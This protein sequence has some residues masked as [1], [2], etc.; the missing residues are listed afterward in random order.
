MTDN[1]CIKEPEKVELYGSNFYLDMQYLNI[2]IVRCTANDTIN[3]NGICLTNDTEFNELMSV[4]YHN[5]S[6]F[7]GFYFKDTL[8]NAGLKYPL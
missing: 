6:N 2:D 8:I 4:I 3:P 1:I 5:V 7:F